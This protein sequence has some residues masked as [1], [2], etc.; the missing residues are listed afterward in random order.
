MQSGKVFQYARRKHLALEKNIFIKINNGLC[1]IIV[2]LL[3]I[4]SNRMLSKKSK[5]KKIPS[6]TLNFGC[7]F[8]KSPNKLTLYLKSIFRYSPFYS[9]ISLHLDFKIA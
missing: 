6:Q 3:Q 7:M 5:I 8:I 4:I 2:S 1:L 9:L